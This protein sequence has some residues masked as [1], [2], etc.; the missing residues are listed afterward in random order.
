MLNSI[1]ELQFSVDFG[2]LLLFLQLAEALPRIIG[3]QQRQPDLPVMMTPPQ[4]CAHSPGKNL[5]LAT[6]EELQL[7]G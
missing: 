6:G 5:S 4:I 1:V 3:R 7:L 2:N